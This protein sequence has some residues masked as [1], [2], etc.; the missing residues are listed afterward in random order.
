M[1]GIAIALLVAGLVS[2]VSCAP[3][4]ERLCDRKCECEGCSAL[5]FD[6][7]L[8]DREGD[9]REA[10]RRDCL[11]EYDDLVACE[12]ATWICDGDDFET[13]CKLEKEDLKACLD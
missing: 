12:N 9:V 11:R 7:C 5:Q 1:K 13:D 8:D 2:S 4:E 3:P 10:D 6:D